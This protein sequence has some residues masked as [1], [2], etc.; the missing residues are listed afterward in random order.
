MKLFTK[1]SRVNLVA[2]IL[3]LLLGGIC[4]YF[5]IRYVLIRQL[6]DTLK[7]EEAEILDHV[8]TRGVLPEPSNY[9][10]QQIQFTP[11]ETK[12]L[13]KFIDTHSYSQDAR[14][15]KPFRQ[16]V[17]PLEVQGRYYTASVSKSEE[18][19]EDLLALIVMITLAVILLLLLIVLLTNRFLL[20]KIWRPFYHTLESIKQFNLSSRQRVDGQDTGIDEFS[21]LDNAVGQMTAKILKDYEMLKNF[22]DNASHEMQTPADPGSFP[23]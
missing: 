23:G 22:A 16:L 4:Y 7:V 1:Y 2:S 15:Y 20:R 18:E 9:R 19:T 21:D 5:I 12:T 13:R 8:R 6:D 17:F 3:V 10:D 11:S 14:M